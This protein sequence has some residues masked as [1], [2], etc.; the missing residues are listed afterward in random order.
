[1]PTFSP[2]IPRFSALL[3]AALALAAIV[4]PSGSTSRPASTRAVVGFHSN[5]ELAAALERFP[6]ATIVR[7]LPHM[8][9]VEVL[10]SGRASDLR[11][12]RGI[13]SSR[14]PLTRTSKV[15]PA[16]TA[17]F[18][19]GL[20]YEWQYVATRVNEVP[21]E[22]LR[23]AGQI[24]IAVVDTGLDVTHPDIA[25]KS[26]ETWDI[27]HH[28]TN[29]A[30][31][32]GHGT[33]VSSLA[34]GSVNNGEGIAGF[35]GDAQLLMVKA[36]GAGDSFSDVDEAAAIIYAVDHGAKIVNL[37]IGGEGTSPLEEKAIQYA[38]AHNVLLVAAGGNEF[39][40]GNPIEYPAAALQPPG[41]KGQGGVG[42][43]VAASTMAGKRAYFSNTGTQISLAAPGANVFGAV[44]AGSRAA[45]WPRY[46]LPGSVAGMYG[47]SSGT[48]FSSPEV[49]G[50]A[51]LVWAANPALNAQEVAGIL[52][53]TAS[54]GGKWE[55]GLGYGIIDVAAAVAAATGQKIAPRVKAGAWL[56]VRRLTTRFGR[57][58][59]AHSGRGLRRV[60][61]EVHLRTSAPIVTPDY[62]SI[63]LQVHRGGSWHRLARTTTRLGGG[64]RWSVGLRPGR[65]I[66]R[67]VYRGRWDLRSAI[68]LKPVQV[69]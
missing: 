17:I 65:H 59:R 34:A 68:Q 37:S 53:S 16:L 40:D 58:T 36:V 23:A 47:W 18:R 14:A 28:R 49:A 30:D 27:V 52:K 9:T 15:E 22:I 42:L 50:A 61:L 26:P 64:I 20:P 69:R 24:K 57:S 62:R 6:G 41:S 29:V 46:E 11:G 4:A 1:M 33:Y 13:A 32:D 31:Q 21:D 25:A 55:P 3:V 2:R 35:G 39:Q 10:L 51:A 67:A 38:T 56:S 44:A 63:T 66:L 43:S 7:R 12:L 8:K 48:S 45:W 19:P 5:A 60:R 54:G